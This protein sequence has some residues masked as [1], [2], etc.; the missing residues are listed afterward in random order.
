MGLMRF[1]LRKRNNFKKEK[2]LRLVRH[3]YLMTIIMAALFVR[4][5]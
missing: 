5:K 3:N 1:C 2:K 4:N